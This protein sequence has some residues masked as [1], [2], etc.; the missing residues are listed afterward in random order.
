MESMRWPCQASQTRSGTR[1]KSERKKTISPIG[2][3]ALTIF[4][5]AAMT[6]K[7]RAEMSLRRIPRSG[8]TGGKPNHGVL[9]R[10][11]PNRP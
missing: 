1:A 2:Y 6:V 5:S 4:I 3:R 8:F 10:A 11:T 7:A 9:H